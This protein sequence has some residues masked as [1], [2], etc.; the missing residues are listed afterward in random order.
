MLLRLDVLGTIRKISSNRT[1]QGDVMQAAIIR[2]TRDVTQ[3]HV[4]SKAVVI[5]LTQHSVLHV[6]RSMRCLAVF[7]II[8]PARL[9]LIMVGFLVVVEVYPAD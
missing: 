9:T 7:F 4:A 6:S 2:T 8:V 3:D 1:T 5:F